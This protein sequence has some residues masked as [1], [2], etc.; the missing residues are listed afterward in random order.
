MSELPSAEQNITTVKEEPPYPPYYSPIPPR[1]SLFDDSSDS[2][3]AP[4]P[5]GMPDPIAWS[6]PAG[7]GSPSVRLTL[8]HR[9]AMLR[10]V[11]DRWVLAQVQHILARGTQEPSLKVLQGARTRFHDAR[12]RLEKCNRR[13]V[14][15][16]CRP[17]TPSAK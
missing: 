13:A 4:S 2:S 10:C 11:A 16:T 15:K 5:D 17:P 3:E 12:D 9:V 6:T 1:E 14:V 7:V 8:R